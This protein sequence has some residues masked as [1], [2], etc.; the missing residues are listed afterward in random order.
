MSD[1]SDIHRLGL[2]LK[3]AYSIVGLVLGLACILVG[4]I[5]GLAGVTGHTGWTASLLGLSTNLNDAGPGVVVLWWVFFS[6]L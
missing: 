1:Q 2:K 4:M 3:F 6:S 5:L